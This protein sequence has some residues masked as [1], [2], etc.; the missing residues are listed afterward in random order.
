MLNS[1][2]LDIPL[3]IK[4]IVTEDRR[5]IPNY[6]LETEMNELAPDGMLGT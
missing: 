5:E 6:S 4:H 1:D 2:R 3:P